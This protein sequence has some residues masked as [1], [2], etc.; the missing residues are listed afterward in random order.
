MQK[1]GFQVKSAGVWRPRLTSLV[2]SHSLSILHMHVN[3]TQI[4]VRENLVRNHIYIVF[5]TMDD[6]FPAGSLCFVLHAHG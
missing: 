5:V 6:F 3:C 1:E 2:S 4:G